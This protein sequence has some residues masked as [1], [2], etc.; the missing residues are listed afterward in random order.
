MVGNPWGFGDHDVFF[1]G[2]LTRCEVLKG[3]VRE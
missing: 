1:L 2:R 3:A